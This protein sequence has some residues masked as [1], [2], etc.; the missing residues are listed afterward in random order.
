M[1]VPVAQLGKNSGAGDAATG[2]GG[3]VADA[4]DAF[5]VAE[6]SP[7]S[8]SSAAK[9]T[10]LDGTEGAH[11]GGAA[12]GE[13]AAGGQGGGGEVG[14]DGDGAD[15]VQEE[16]LVAR[17]VVC[18]RRQV[19]DED[20]GGVCSVCL[21]RRMLSSV[22]CVDDMSAVADATAGVGMLYYCPSCD[23]FGRGGV[24]DHEVLVLGMFRGDW[25][26]WLTGAERMAPIFLGIESD[27]LPSPFL[28]RQYLLQ[29]SPGTRC[30]VCSDIASLDGLYSRLATLCT[31]SCWAHADHAAAAAAHPWVLSLLEV[32][33]SAQPEQLL[34]LFCTTCREAFLYGDCHC[35]DHHD[36]LLPLVFHSRM[37]LCVQIS[38]GHWLWSV[39][40]SIADAE[41]AADILHSSATSTRLIPIRGRTAQRCR[42][43]QKRLLDG[44]GTTCSLR[45][46]LSPG[47]SIAYLPSQLRYGMAA[48]P[49]SLPFFLLHFSQTD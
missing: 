17:C 5:L 29:P 10:G 16:A 20:E 49:S 26:A 2:G 44:G 47:H 39:W 22:V 3:E 28:G 15:G 21:R 42:W 40:E 32:G 36:H 30:R 11:D 45:C 8:S 23:A 41:L 37:G 24:H 18:L 35:D 33:C 43:C 7:R 12:G 9:E 48:A 34:D 14:P 31:I 27:R 38:R 19:A 6:S 46:R 1:G 25:C 4:M 13:A